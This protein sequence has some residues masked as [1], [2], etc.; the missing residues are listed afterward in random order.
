ML[1]KLL[2]DESP[3]VIVQLLEMKCAEKKKA[4]EELRNKFDQVRFRIENLVKQSHLMRDKEM[5]FKLREKRSSSI[6]SRFV[7]C[8][9]ALLK[10]SSN[11]DLMKNGL[12][13]SH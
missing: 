1:Q 6:V 7:C 12:L 4:A 9:M 3:T 5:G 10:V 8:P 13:S 2:G 11:Y